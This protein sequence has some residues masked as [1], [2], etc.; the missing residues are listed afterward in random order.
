MAL[1]PKKKG[2]T[3]T[4]AGGEVISVTVTV[5]NKIEFITAC[6]IT[7]RQ[8]N[9]NVYRYVLDD[10]RELTHNRSLGYVDLATKLLNL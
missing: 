10:G 9:S 2:L 1:P 4:D 8:G 3:R 7:T 6:A 5:N